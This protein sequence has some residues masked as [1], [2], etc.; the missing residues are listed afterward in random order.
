M[1]E[2]D[3]KIFN[4]IWAGASGY[5]LK[6]T[7]P[8]RLIEAITEVNAGGAPMNPAIAAKVFQL[9]Q[10]FA[11]PAREM[12]KD[13][14]LLLSKR[15]KEI[16]ELIMEGNNFHNISDKIFISYETVRTHVRS[17]YKKL[18]VTSVNQ[19]IVKALKEEAF[20]S[21]FIFQTSTKAAGFLVLCILS[22]RPVFSLNWS[23][24]TCAI[25]LPVVF[26]LI[27]SIAFSSSSSLPFFV[28]SIVDGQSY[29]F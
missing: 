14:S 23:I 24:G 21:P 5:V 4:S 17:I 15:E 29:R 9:F 6:N 10:R 19:V 8:S 22:P 11:P 26:A 12:E 3:D 27:I 25:Y 20:N 28:P 13:E 2:D 1:F 18:H 7:A 16:L